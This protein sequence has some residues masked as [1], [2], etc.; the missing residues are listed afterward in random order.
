MRKKAFIV[1]LSLSLSIAFF[2]CF[3]F[4]FL[5]FLIFLF[6]SLSLRWFNNDCFLIKLRSHLI[7][8][9]RYLL[10]LTFL[11]VNKRKKRNFIRLPLHHIYSSF[12]LAHSIN[13]NLYL[14]WDEQIVIMI[15]NN[16]RG[17]RQLIRRAAAAAHFKMF[18]TLLFNF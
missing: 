17:R 10:N 11:F 2:V 14:R 18:C 3:S 5:F 1:S 6:Y 12:S 7:S 16:R 8:S 4:F 15:T 13:L 9:F